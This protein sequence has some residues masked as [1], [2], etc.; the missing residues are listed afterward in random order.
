VLRKALEAAILFT[1][2][3]CCNDC[4]G[5]GN[6]PDPEYRCKCV[7]L[8]GKAPYKK[9][10][11]RIGDVECGDFCFPLDQPNR[12]HWAFWRWWDVRAAL[13][14]LYEQ[15]KPLEEEEFKLSDIL[16]EEP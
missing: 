15:C 5:G 3:N 14:R 16:E 9:I 8:F 2:R 7:D 6:E 4:D 10:I 12:K 1:L 11:C 13:F